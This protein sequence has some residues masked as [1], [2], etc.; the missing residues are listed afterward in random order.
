MSTESTSQNFYHELKKLIPE[1]AK[2]P[3]VVRVIVDA[4]V[5]EYPVMSIEAILLP[6]T[7]EG[8]LERGMRVF[9][10]VPVEE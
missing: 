5:G 8:E 1:L 7:P 9:R 6:S 4:K 2:I 3:N 10:I